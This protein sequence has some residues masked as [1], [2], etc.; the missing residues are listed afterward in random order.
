MAHCLVETVQSIYQFF[1]RTLQLNS[2]QQILTTNRYDKLLRQIVA[3]NRYDKLLL[4]IVMKK[5]EIRRSNVFVE[6][7]HLC[8]YSTF[9]NNLT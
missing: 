9:F 1:I 8:Q 2:L 6:I 3:T 7:S 4:Q 5:D